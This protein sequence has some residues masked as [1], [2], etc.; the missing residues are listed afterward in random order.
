MWGPGALVP[1]AAAPHS[2]MLPEQEQASEIYQCGPNAN[3]SDTARFVFSVQL[4]DTD[5]VISPTLYE[6]DLRHTE[7]E[8][9]P[10]GHTAKEGAL[11]TSA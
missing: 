5:T 6:G 2:P 3:H 1:P 8:T 7:M 9:L 10:Q 11:R 4:Y